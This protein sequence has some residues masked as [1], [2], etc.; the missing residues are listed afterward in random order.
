MALLV[1]ELNLTRACLSVTLLHAAYLHPHA[2]TTVGSRARKNAC[3]PASMPSMLSN[4]IL[5]VAFASH[6]ESQAIVLRFP[7]GFLV[8]CVGSV[9]AVPQSKR[10]E[11]LSRQ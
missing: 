7:F 1:S 2:R 6:A 3:H 9:V 4:L 8:P 5:W 11:G 10:R